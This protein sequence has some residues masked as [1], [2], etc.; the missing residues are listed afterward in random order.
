M[1]REG[2][3]DWPRSIGGMPIGMSMGAVTVSN[4]VSYT[5]LRAHETVLDIV[6]R[7]LLEKQQ[8]KANTAATRHLNDTKSHL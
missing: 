5:H 7:L 1:K 2:S 3:N 6:C 4:A 8:L